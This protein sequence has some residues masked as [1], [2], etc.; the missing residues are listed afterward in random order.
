MK[1]EESR[2]AEST[3]MEGMISFR[4]VVAGI[5]AKAA[6]KAAKAAQVQEVA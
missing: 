2:F 1:R 6:A 5:E 4:A 3:L